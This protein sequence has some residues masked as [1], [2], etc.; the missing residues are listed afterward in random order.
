MKLLKFS[1]LI[2]SA[3]LCILILTVSLMLVQPNWFKQPLSRMLERQTGL[4]LTVER[5][6]TGIAP[7]SV[8][9]QNISLNNAEGELLFSAGK[10]ALE[11]SNWPTLTAPFFTLSLTAPHLSYQLDENGRS[12]WPRGTAREESSVAPTAFVLPGDFSFYRIALESG[13]IDIDLPALKRHIAIPTLVLARD[14]EDKATLQLLTE[15]DGERFELKGDFKLASENMLDIHLGLI[16]P[17]IESLLDASLSTRPQLDGT[18]GQ[19]ELNLH[20]TDFLSRLLDTQMPKIPGASLSTHFAIGEHYRLT[21]L[22]LT[23]GEQSL[24]GGADY[25]P[26]DNHLTLDLHT[27]KLALD[28][29]L[30]VINASPAESRSAEALVSDTADEATDA[31]TTNTAKPEADIDWRALSGIELDADI[32]IGDFSGF[33]WTGQALSAHAVLRNRDSNAPKIAIAASGKQIRNAAQKVDLDS[34]ALE[35]DLRA[36]ALTTSGVDA[37]VDVKLQINEAIKLNAS[38]RA[39]LN[40]VTGQDFRLDITAPNS[41]E[42]WRLAGLPYAEAGPLTI[43][44][45]FESE[46]AT[47]K[48]DLAIALGDQQLDID[49]TYTPATKA[50]QRPYI[51]V[52]ANGRNIDTRFTSPASEAPPVVAE[53]TGSTRLFSDEPIDTEFLRSFDADLSLDIKKLVTAVNTIDQLSLIAQLKDGRLTSRESRVQIPD[54][55]LTLSLN[56]DFRNAASKAQVELELNT[57][58][59]GK[60]GLE[61]AAK[62]KGGHGKVTIKLKGEGTSP[63]GIAESLNGSIELMLQDMVMANNQLNLVGSDIFSQLIDTLNPFAKSDPETHLECVSI[64]FDADKGVLESDKA[65]HFETRKM[66]IIGNGEIDLGKE[67]LSLNFTPIARKGLGVNLSYLVKLVAVQGD[68]QSPGIGVDAGGLVSSALSTSAAFATGGV[69]LVAQSLL[70]RAVN[71]G[72]ACN[73]DKKLD[74]EIPEAADT[75]TAPT[76]ESP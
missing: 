66:K 46:Q 29:L 57:K 43:K 58:N 7:A 33:G 8:D 34:L 14:S 10:I 70:E 30:A 24:S 25:S 31:L 59:A 76:A 42:L 71:A 1:L 15:I 60:L 21:D 52:T 63:H 35:S 3:L 51:S 65:L 61:Q 22:L 49:V 68:L 64:H 16:N 5:I 75:A 40:G 73:P 18:D 20:N 32:R 6:D 39:N 44:G 17:S 48:P 62:I 36:L 11:L 50:E 19:I 69:S 74:L 27:D 55:D 13:Q 47:L 2:L 38:G 4:H 12:N 53:K 56:G 45:A 41:A 72:S 54:S 37:D 67:R 9:M 28:E 26:A 23:V